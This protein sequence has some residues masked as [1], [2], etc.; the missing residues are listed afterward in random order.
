MY[1]LISSLKLNVFRIIALA[2]LITACKKEHEEIYRPGKIKVSIDITD[3]T[4][5]FLGLIETHGTSK[6]D[7]I[8]FLLESESN[9]N[10]VTRVFRLKKLPPLPGNFDFKLKNDFKN[11]SIYRLSAFYKDQVGFTYTEKINFSGFTGYGKM[12]VD[13]VSPLSGRKG[14]VVVIYG[15]NFSCRSRSML[16]HVGT[17]EAKIIS[18]SINRI[19]LQVPEQ[20]YTG[21][22]PISVSLGSDMVVTQKPFTMEGPVIDYFTPKSGFGK[23]TID[24][25]GKGFNP[26]P[27]L[28]KAQLIYGSIG[29][30][31]VEVLEASEDHLKISFDLIHEKPCYNFLLIEGDGISGLAHDT[32]FI[33]TPWKRLPD[34]PSGYLQASASFVIDNKIYICCGYDETITLRNKLWEYDNNTKVWNRKADFPGGPKSLAFGFSINGKGYIGGGG[35]GDYATSDFWEYNPSSDS[36]KRLADIPGTDKYYKFGFS[37]NGKGYIGDMTNPRVFY[38]YDPLTDTWS[39]IL[40]F[41]G[42]EKSNPI[43]SVMGN[44]LLLMES[45]AFISESRD[46]WKFDLINESWTYIAPQ[47][48][49]PIEVFSNDTACYILDNEMMLSRFFPE[50]GENKEI[51]IFPG[52]NRFKPCISKMIGNEI[53]IGLGSKSQLTF[54]DIWS[55]S[56]K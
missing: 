43:W 6:F 46:I 29:L 23:I 39:D 26:I 49:T 2:V 53:F 21:K 7:S 34:L 14:D 33:T 9:P 31:P 35:N 10:L 52:E 45:L 54:R 47:V 17:A 48:V 42:I 55:Y 20:W 38:K 32:L 56:I 4:V 5:T 44:N 22:Y 30:L 37:A 15:K 12:I 18:N 1:K 11:D 16:V 3:D 40:P 41:P 13:S 25:Y 8:G 24:V 28:N 36:W 27:S 19:V 51:S 50:T